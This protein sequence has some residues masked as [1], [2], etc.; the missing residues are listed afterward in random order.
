MQLEEAT[1]SNLRLNVHDFPELRHT[2][3]VAITLVLL[4]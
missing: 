1:T 2:Q 3:A 4:N